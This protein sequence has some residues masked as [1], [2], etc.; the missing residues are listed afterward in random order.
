MAIHS[1]PAKLVFPQ[2]LIATLILPIFSGLLT[3]CASIEEK[4]FESGKLI[5]TE[6]KNLV[7]FFDGTAN[8][9]EVPT[10]IFR[11]Y[12]KLEQSKDSQ[13]VAIYMDGVGNEET[14]LGKIFGQGIGTGMEKRILNGYRFLVE[15]YQPNDRIFIFGFSRGAFTARSLSG[16]ISYA[17]IPKKEHAELDSIWDSL[18]FTS[19]FTIGNKILEFTREQNDNAYKEQWAKW[20]QGDDPVLK[21]K[22]KNEITSALGKPKAI[23][24]QSAEVEFLGIWDTVP[25][26]QGIDYFRAGD[27]VCKQPDDT[28]EDKQRYQLDSYP[29]I[30]YIAHALSKDEKRTQF[31]PLFLCSEDIKNTQT[32]HN[33]ELTT[34]E[35]RVFPGAHAD[36]GGGYE[37]KNNQLPEISLTWMIEQLAQHYQ[38]R[39]NKDG[40]LKN[41]ELNP[42]PKGLADLSISDKIG[43]TRSDCSDRKIPSHIRNHESVGVRNQADT[44]PW[45]YFGKNPKT[46]IASNFDKSCIRWVNPISGINKKDK[47]L[48][49]KQEQLSCDSL[50]KLNLITK[51]K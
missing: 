27:M 17:G 45:L 38:L 11:L 21:Q 51:T 47:I 9:P 34:L 32:V 28:T 20:K 26:S 12:R 5:H 10:N 13:T 48:C 43:S 19:G 29:P 44:T 35:E 15:N 4:T 49:L 2:H 3:S 24:V 7:V 39:P 50:E 46:E 1:S 22:I 30:H 40:F 36:V 16:L 23:E 14:T 37:H 42:N 8:N 31:K 18:P 25:G 33:K 41:L 6:P